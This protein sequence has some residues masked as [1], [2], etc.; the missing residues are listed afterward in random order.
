MLLLQKLFLHERSGFDIDIFENSQFNIS[1]K[2]F[3]A[4]HKN[5]NLISGTQFYKLYRSKN[6]PTET[7]NKIQEGFWADFF[8]SAVQS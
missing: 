2:E 3:I 1:L 6:E 5:L 8:N 7:A 4:S